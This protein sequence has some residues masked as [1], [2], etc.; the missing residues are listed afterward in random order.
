MIAKDWFL[1]LGFE[2]KSLEIGEMH[3]IRFA[4]YSGGEG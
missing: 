4:K 3:A 2:K 1:P